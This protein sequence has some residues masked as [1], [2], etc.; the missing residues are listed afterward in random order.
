[1]GGRIIWKP[2]A[3][4]ELREIQIYIKQEFG[5]NVLDKF[6]N[7]L[8]EKTLKLE[9]QPFA[10]RQ[11]IV[12]NV[13]RMKIYKKTTLFYKIQKDDIVILKISDVRE[14]PDKNPYL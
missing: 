13:R 8:F 5:K 9:A 2:K 11:T 12:K 7:D 14:N 6:L 1:M 4:N 10:G 3:L